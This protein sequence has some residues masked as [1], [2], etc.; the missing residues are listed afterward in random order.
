MN[1]PL[2]PFW[3]LADTNSWI[4]YQD[5]LDRFP[6]DVAAS[7]FATNDSGDAVCWILNQI[8]AGNSFSLSAQI[9]NSNRF[10]F[11]V[12]GSSLDVNQARLPEL[13]LD[14]ADRW[15]EQILKSPSRIEF[16]TSGTGGAPKISE[17]TIESLARGLKF[18]EAQSQSRWGTG[19]PVDHFA[20]MQVLLQAV[21]NRN[22][23]VDFTNCSAEIARRELN[24]ETL[25]HFSATPTFY[26]L[27]LSEPFRVN[28]MQRV[29]VGGER[30]TPSL[31]AALKRAFPNARI[32]NVYASTELGAFCPATMTRLLCLL[33]NRTRSRFPMVSCLFENRAMASK[34]GTVPGTR[35]SDQSGTT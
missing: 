24:C 11:A 28:S 7:E 15:I 1:F 34:C 13:L 30:L 3:K 22:P 33:K 23:V 5:C 17:H 31:L 29:V 21:L 2:P 6:A 18:G 12:Y 26:R 10:Q 25:T 19:F 4:S 27:L 8:L 9:G 32:R 20:G 35:R 14:N 16:S